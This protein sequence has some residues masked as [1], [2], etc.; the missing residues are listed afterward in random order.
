MSRV[1][2][3]NE[4][5]QRELSDLLHTRYRERAVGITITEVSVMPD[6]RS[7]RVYYSVLGNAMARH[8]ADSLIDEI[9][10]DLRARVFKRVVLKYTP[11]LTF[12]YD[13]S[14]IR[15]NRTLAI[16]DDLEAR[17]E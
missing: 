2:R 14:F 12:H 8:E 5:L 15:G 6:L 11:V 13:D 7:A 9:K 17:G 4:L 1:H 3:I 10:G 16:L